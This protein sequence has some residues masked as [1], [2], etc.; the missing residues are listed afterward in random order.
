MTFRTA[1]ATA[2]PL[3]HKVGGLKG[4]VDL[5]L[6][7][8]IRA[9]WAE[10]VDAMALASP[11][12]V[13]SADVAGV[14]QVLGRSQPL[15]GQGSWMSAVRMASCTLAGVVSACTTRRGA[16]ASQVWVR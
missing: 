12:E 3:H 8:L 2:L 13:F 5:L 16:P 4:T 9:G 10:Q 11:D 14:H 7:A 15:G 6:P 1:H